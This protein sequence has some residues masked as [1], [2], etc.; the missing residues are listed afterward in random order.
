MRQ[1]AWILLLAAALTGCM[2]SPMARSGDSPEGWQGTRPQLDPE[3]DGDLLEAELVTV[4]W[5]SISNSPLVLLRELGSGQIVPIWVGMA[6]GQ[7]IAIGLHEIA[8]P[9][10]MTHDLMAGLLRELGAEL[11]EVV[12]H[13]LVDGTYLGALRIRPR[14][15]EPVLV[16]TRPSDGM[17][18]AIRTGAPIR[19]HRKIVQEVPDFEFLP[20]EPGEQVVRS[21]GLTVVSVSEELRRERGFPA[22]GGVL[23][24]RATGEA[25]RAG[26]RRGDLIVKVNGVRPH[27]PI[28]FLEA[29]RRSQRNEPVR[30][31][32]WRDGTE[33]EVEV[34]QAPPE[35]PRTRGP[36]VRA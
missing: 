18:L 24:T 6:E 27:E 7:A 8:V 36:D 20:P 26:L 21:L 19:V 23:V 33:R 16:D 5:D 12:V 10:P 25:A 1:I 9:R 15:G 29:V 32:Y 35:V 11:I 28:A 4:G 2:Y 17:A 13:D 22:E 14:G 34:K 30:I 31:R 3:A